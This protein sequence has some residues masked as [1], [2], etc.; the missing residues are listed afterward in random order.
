MVAEGLSAIWRQKVAFFLDGRHLQSVYLVGNGFVLV[1][2]GANFTSMFTSTV[3]DA[4][5]RYSADTDTVFRCTE[6]DV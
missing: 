1:I 5:V 6:V 3:R 4:S 2:L